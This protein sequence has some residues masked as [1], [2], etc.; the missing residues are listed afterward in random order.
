M[1]KEEGQKAFTETWRVMREFESM[2]FNNDNW[3]QQLIYKADMLPEQYQAGSDC[4]ILRRCLAI[5]M[6]QYFT[7]LYRLQKGVRNDL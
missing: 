3:W 7:E 5:G 4:E 1:T 2:D 6:L